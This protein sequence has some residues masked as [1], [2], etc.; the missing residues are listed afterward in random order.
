MKL[1]QLLIL[2]FISNSLLGL[3]QMAIGSAGIEDTTQ[4]N[5]SAAINLNVDYKNP[6]EYTIGPISV[7]GAENFDPNAIR[8]VA[9]LRPG[10]KI[11]IPGQQ[12]ADAINNLWRE[13]LFS[14]V[15]I[16]AEKEI[17][18][19]IYLTIKVAPRAK[20]ARY[21]F[22]GVSKRE[23]DKIREQIDLYTGRTIS[24]NLIYQ[25]ESK[26]KGYYREEGFYAVKVNI[27]R[28]QDNVMNNSEIFTIHVDKGKK[29]GIKEINFEGNESIKDG[30]LRRAMKDTKQKSIIRIFKRSKFTESAYE[31]DKLAVLS[32]FN[33]I[34]LRDAALVFD[35]VYMR[36]AKNLI[37]NI[38]V[39]EG[40]EY[41]FGD[42]TWIGNTKFRS[43][44]LGDTVLG[45]QKGDKYNK[46]LL[47]ERLRMDQEGGG[48]DISSL[49]MDRGY[50]FFDIQAVETDII[51]NHINYEMRI[52]EGKE[53]RVGTVTIRGNT[54]TNDYV[55]LRE[56]RTKPG[57][58]FSRS[59]IMRT[60]RE[61]AQLGYF[62][63]QAFQVN[64][65]PNPQDGTVDIEYVVEEKSSDQIELSGGYGGQNYQ[66]QK[67]MI[68]GTLGLTINNFSLR[69][70]FKKDRWKPLP[71][72]D[73]QR[74]SL[75]GQT[76]GKY[77]QS[78]NFSFSEPWL[79]G[80]KPNSF[81]VYM[82]HTLLGN[83]YLRK[84]EEYQGISITGVGV[85]LGRRKRFP[86]NYFSESIELGYQ[87]Y[88][89]TDYVYF[90]LFENGYSN[91][92]SLKY[93]IQR[94]SVSS[95]IYAQSGSV[96]TFSAKS[97]LPYSYFDGIS[98]YSTIS[99]Q[100]KFKYLEYYKLKLSGEWFL[101][102]TA[103]KK[104]V[105]RPRIGFGYMGAYTSSKGISPFERFYL[106]GSG[107]SGVNQI[108]GREVIAVRGYDDNSISSASGDPIAAKYTLE[109]R[110]PISLNPSAT[111]YVL[112][113]AE[114]GNSYPSFKYFNPLNVKRSVGAG[115][116]VF[117]PMFG[118][119]G[120]DYGF[121][122]DQL[123][124][125]SN[126][127]GLDSDVRIQQKGYYG[128]LTFT[129]GMNLGEL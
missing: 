111:F 17:A 12:I 5:S 32:K 27:Q 119:L 63:E 96:I 68:I 85:S 10:Q 88:D 28:S 59:D 89:V 84:R 29:V 61:L 40:E 21:R 50:L 65:M 86:D 105:L 58:L 47:E 121:G 82:N 91:D 127:Y 73:G 39:E 13:G 22:E 80:K 26:I 15:Q 14:D 9:G 30:K 4:T 37:I 66:T 45:I 87:Y 34:G 99:Q 36:D 75:R 44:F 92:I 25:T 11:T 108:G 109:L 118:M 112:A 70:M 1:T 83:G 122:F 23:A 2:L 72:G 54:K 123:N 7:I 94:N 104:L 101:P 20:L 115:L 49:Y 24:E 107:L 57:D 97:T 125:W 48:R 102:L 62:N 8:L 81:S 120:I 76:N 129:I 113:F 31:R 42:I 100:D 53:A 124:P 18:G 126:G 90:T 46:P 35:T 43:S 117:L 19:V 38:K 79:G 56:I 55:I 33:A 6:K 110:Y 95:P 16:Y 116:R 128:K 103:D 78:Y 64:P 3:S 41:Y 114:A 74:L 52:R 106:G 98:D 51:D 60:Q 93:T 67:P 69:N 77:F 71:S